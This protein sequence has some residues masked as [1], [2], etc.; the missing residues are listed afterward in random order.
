MIAMPNRMSVTAP[1]NQILIFLASALF[2][3]LSMERTLGTYDEGVIL[4][5][6]MRVAAGDVPHRDFYANYGPAQFYL[7]AALFKLFGQY[8]VVE[9]ALEVLV[10]ALIVTVCYGLTT[11]CCRRSIALAASIVCG[12]WLFSLAF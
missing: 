11:A 12:L 1:T 3:S 9:R 10:R 5:G 4:T 6:A 2:F 8:V 7:L